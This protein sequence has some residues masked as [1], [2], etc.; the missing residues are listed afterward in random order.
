MGGE[1]DETALA[2]GRVE[3]TLETFMK[4]YDD[5]KQANIHLQAQRDEAAAIRH[6]ETCE[7]VKGV[8]DACTRQIAA[9]SERVTALDDPEKGTVRKLERYVDRQ[10]TTVK[11]VSKAG[12]VIGALAAFWASV[13]G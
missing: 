5:G 3:G 1:L 9:V 7:L 2:I 4:S 6:K 12:G 10:K 8:A 13:R 11:N